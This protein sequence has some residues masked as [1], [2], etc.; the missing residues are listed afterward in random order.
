MLY[1]EG[2][3]GL[4]RRLC[5]LL[6]CTD[7]LSALAPKPQEVYGPYASAPA[8]RR[9]PLRVVR[10]AR[11]GTGSYSS[12]C[13]RIFSALDGWE[14]VGDPVLLVDT[15][16]LFWRQEPFLIWRRHDKIGRCA[17]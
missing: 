16:E 6:V 13:L 15:S 11:Q 10:A 4:A 3:G 2:V 14:D 7:P 5:I 8:R 12:S 1:T 9:G 17:L